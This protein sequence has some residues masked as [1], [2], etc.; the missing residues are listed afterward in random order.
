[1]PLQRTAIVLWMAWVQGRVAREG[2]PLLRSPI[3][4]PV[5]FSSA[6]GGVGRS[7]GKSPRLDGVRRNPGPC[8]VPERQRPIPMGR[9]RGPLLRGRSTKAPTGGGKTQVRIPRRLGDGG[10]IR[11]RVSSQRP[12]HSAEGMNRLKCSRSGGSQTYT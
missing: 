5:T 8:A 1:M 12:S 11:P 7:I 3:P 6:G 10:H 4:A 9:G 2:A